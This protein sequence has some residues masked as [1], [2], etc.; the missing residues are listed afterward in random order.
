[1]LVELSGDEL[2][3]LEP[4]DEKMIVIERFFTPDLLDPTLLAGRSLVLMPANPAAQVAFDLFRAALDEKQTWALGS[5]VFSQK[6]QLVVIHSRN[7]TVL[8]HTLH[9]PALQ[10]LPVFSP[11]NG[12]SPAPRDVKKLARAMDDCSMPIIWMDYRDISHVRLAA[13]VAAKVHEQSSNTGKNRTT[14]LA[15]LAG[16][17]AKAA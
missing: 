17:S 3:Q 8:L 14:R 12:A 16:V 5:T 4:V 7:A 1:L 15:R 11:P 2:A 9:D 10:R 6:R 13:L